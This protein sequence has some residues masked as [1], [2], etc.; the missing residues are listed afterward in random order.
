MRHC[1]VVVTPD[2]DQQVTR[3]GVRTTHRRGRM[4]ADQRAELARLLGTQGLDPHA[5]GTSPP[6]GPDLDAAFGRRAPR[7]LDI[8]PGTGDATRASAES[9]PDCNVLAVEVH[10]PGLLRLLRLVERDGPANVRAIEADAQVV[11]AALPGAFHGIRILFPDPWPKRRHR[12][13]R[14]VDPVFVRT[15]T[16]ALEPDGF[17]HLATDW[18]EYAEQ[19]RAALASDA[20]LRL[21]VD[22]STEPGRPSPPRKPVRPITTYEQRGLHAGRTITDLVATR[23][24]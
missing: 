4:N 18:A 8:G 6:T 7:L 20:R 19:M 12:H 13:R 17:L 9:H 16:D 11:V 22:V 24:D 10:Q 21:D 15:A 3:Q 23:L 5:W 2:P 14:L 1:A